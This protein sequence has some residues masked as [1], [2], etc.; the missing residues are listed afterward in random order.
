MEVTKSEDTESLIPCRRE[1]DTYTGIIKEEHTLFQELFLFI[2]SEKKSFLVIL[3]FPVLGGLFNQLMIW[4]FVPVIVT[5]V[6]E[7]FEGFAP[8]LSSFAPPLGE[9]VA[10]FLMW[11]PTYFSGPL[12]LLPLLFGTSVMLFSFY[13]VLWRAG[14]RYLE[15]QGKETPVSMIKALFLICTPSIFVGLLLN[16]FTTPFWLFEWIFTLLL[17]TVFPFLGA[18]VRIHPLFSAGYLLFGRSFVISIV[19]LFGDVFV[20]IILFLILKR[21]K[22]QF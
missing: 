3:L 15:L 4:Y 19:T 11:F 8:I 17:V 10:D 6:Y 12:Y 20:V 22:K 7:I 5:V 18:D 2:S 1:P 14:S 9:S 13:P 21:L 16:S